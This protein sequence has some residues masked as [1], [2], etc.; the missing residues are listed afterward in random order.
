MNNL[1]NELL[2]VIISYLDEFTK[3]RLYQSSSIPYVN[4][5]KIYPDGTII[6][7][8][9]YHDENVNLK[10]MYIRK[11]IV[12]RTKLQYYPAG[13]NTLVI[14]E[15][16][17]PLIPPYQ[18]NKLIISDSDKI[19]QEFLQ[20]FESIIMDFQK[21]FLKM[22]LPN[23]K[24]LKIFGIYSD[25]VVILSKITP[26]LEYLETTS[27]NM[28][29]CKNIPNLKV[30]IFARG[31]DQSFVLTS[32]ITELSVNLPGDIVFNKP[33]NLKKL[34][35]VFAPEFYSTNLTHLIITR[36]H[37]EK[38][39]L[40]LS[41]HNLIYLKLPQIFWTVN[42]NKLL[43]PN[44][45]TLHLTEANKIMDPL[46]LDK[47]IID[48]I[49]N[50]CIIENYVPDPHEDGWISF[51]EYHNSIPYYIDLQCHSSL[52]KIPEGVKSLK[53]VGQHDT[54]I[55]PNSLTCLELILDNLEGTINLPS[56]L[57][58]L[59][60]KCVHP[61]I[62]LIGPLHLKYLKAHKLFLPCDI[63]DKV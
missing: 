61:E 30:K 50:C 44:L 24:K 18:I 51:I 8:M 54:I 11:L 3:Y 15:L 46:P 26:N 63:F 32:N 7:K 42:G 37:S 31:Y 9:K 49:G 60:A 52:V 21:K 39:I 19:S 13:L 5:I 47:F 55:F 23:L 17:K 45:K 59:I 14:K 62:I 16:R 20:M 1:A 57:Q 53:L 25:E 43:N 48:N 34:C 36:T 6:N 29:T 35:Y 33:I 2:N 10:N 41:N 4:K 27:C 12:K 38:N 56:G 28:L 22:C 40:N 58:M